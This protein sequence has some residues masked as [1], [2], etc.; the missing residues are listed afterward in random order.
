M[1]EDFRIVFV[2]RS[3]ENLSIK[4]TAEI[5]DIK[6]ETVKSRHFRAKQLLK[7]Q[8]EQLFAKA[9]LNVYEFGGAHCDS[10]ILSVLDRIIGSKT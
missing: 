4:E 6:Q 5:L 1:K 7:T 9:N 8:M 2:L 3:I 10:I